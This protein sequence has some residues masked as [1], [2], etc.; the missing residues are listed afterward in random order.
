MKRECER[1]KPSQ[2]IGHL[3]PWLT[4]ARQGSNRLLEIL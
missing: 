2:H 1:D 4:A 3:P